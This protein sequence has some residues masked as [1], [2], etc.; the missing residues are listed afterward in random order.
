MNNQIGDNNSNIEVSEKIENLHSK[1]VHTEYI[2]IEAKPYSEARGTLEHIHDD[3]LEISEEKT[4]VNNNK[5]LI[6]KEKGE[7]KQELYPDV[8][9]W[10]PQIAGMQ[11]QEKQERINALLK[12]TSRDWLY[13]DWLRMQTG[14]YLEY[15]SDK[16]ISYSYGLHAEWGPSYGWSDINVA[17][18]IDIENEKRVLLDDF[19]YLDDESFI[20]N[21]AKYCF[22]S[23]EL[24]DITRENLYAANRSI[25]EYR[26]EKM[27]NNLLTE[28]GLIRLTS[29]EIYP[30]FFLRPN[31]LILNYY[32]WNE[33]ELT[34]EL[35]VFI[36]YLKVEPWE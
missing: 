23:E 28:N 21:F 5:M 3:H 14:L 29:L 16:Y 8:V 30:T 22:G 25:E 12:D 9:Y 6:Y 11:D 27:E 35:P 31:R 20:L 24:V 32:K 33:G 13:V 15:I 34:M 19:V 36:E 10:V 17:V 1:K 7:Y 18:T 26:Q 4:S 2:T